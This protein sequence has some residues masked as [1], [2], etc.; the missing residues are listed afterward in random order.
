MW[1]GQ[2]ASPMF[3]KSITYQTQA[4]MVHRAKPEWRQVEKLFFLAGSIML[5]D[6]TH[7]CHSI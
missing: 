4:L 2:L 5:S 7:S 3:V 6:L 1:T